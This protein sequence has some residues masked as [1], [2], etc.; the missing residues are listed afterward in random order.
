MS[1]TPFVFS[2][3]LLL[4]PIFSRSIA[5]PFDYHYFLKTFFASAIIGFPDI[6][7]LRGSGAERV[8]YLP[9]SN[10]FRTATCSSVPT[11]DYPKLRL[12][13]VDRRC[14]TRSKTL[15]IHRDLGSTQ[16]LVPL[17]G[18]GSLAYFTK[19]ILRSESHR[20]RCFVENGM[21]YFS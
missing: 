1:D 7:R 13:L 9:Y 14:C 5:S 12:N 8:S 17:R 16:S 10:S 3:L 21:N 2:S 6:P 20:F 4:R 18:R 11:V 19:R 15:G